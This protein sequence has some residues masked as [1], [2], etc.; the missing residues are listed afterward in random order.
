MQPIKDLMRRYDPKEARATFVGPKSAPL[1]GGPRGKSRFR[2]VPK[3]ALINLGSAYAPR[4]LKS[5]S[6]NRK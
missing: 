3:P 2:K 5:M 6:V 4:G 1:S